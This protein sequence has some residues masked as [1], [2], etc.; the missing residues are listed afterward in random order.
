MY[1]QT[2]KEGKEKFCF[3]RGI[4][5]DP[6][7]DF[8]IDVRDA[9]MMPKIYNLGDCLII[10]ESGAPGFWGGALPFTL[11]QTLDGHFL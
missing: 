5:P 7:F 10:I 9:G 3:W 1:S 6:T 4:M 11:G 8:I 2:V